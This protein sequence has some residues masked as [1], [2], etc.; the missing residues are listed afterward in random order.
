MT[1]SVTRQAN[2]PTDAEEQEILQFA[3]SL[4]PTDGDVIHHLDSSGSVR[5]YQRK[6]NEIAAL[7]GRGSTLLDWGCLYGQMTYLLERRG[8]CVTP[9]DIEASRRS[10]TLCNVVGRTPVYT[11]D[12]VALSF[13]D[14]SFDA[15]LSSGT[16]EH[17]VDP[18]ASLEEIS[19]IL[20][21]NGWLIVYNLPNRL[22]WI[23]F[24]GR[25][26][27]TVHERCYGAAGQAM[28]CGSRLP[29][30]SCALR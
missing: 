10:Q 8:L 16:L 14:E 24:I 21:P 18:D 27:G 19:R 1:S 28:D 23:E 4:R 5:R 29:G 2:S 30:G 22:S 13:P 7:L 25:F 12:P 3:L 26:R 17:V 15:V 6:A 11:R 9:F 20:R